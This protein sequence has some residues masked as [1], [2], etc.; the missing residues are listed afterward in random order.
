MNTQPQVAPYI[1]AL[2]FRVRDASD[3][4]D[5]IDDGGTNDRRQ[6]EGTGEL[7]AVSKVVAANR[8][9]HRR[10]RTPPSNVLAHMI[11]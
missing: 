10:T 4:D 8:T 3:D 6:A 9:P 7:C 5:A 1:W 11:V 2:F